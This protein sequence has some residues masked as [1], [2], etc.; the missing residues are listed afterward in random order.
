M[1]SEAHGSLG[2]L[3]NIEQDYVQWNSKLLIRIINMI[4]S[5]THFNT[6]LYKIIFAVAGTGDYV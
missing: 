4:L 2:D 3:L 6:I 5:F 1:K